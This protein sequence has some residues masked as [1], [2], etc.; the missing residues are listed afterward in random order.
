MLPSIVY[1][2]L[3]VLKVDT[4][5]RL[6]K[7]ISFWV[8]FVVVFFQSFTKVPSVTQFHFHLWIAFH[9][10]PSIH[11]AR[12]LSP[13]SFTVPLYNNLKMQNWAVMVVSRKYSIE[14]TCGYGLRKSAHSSKC[15]FI[16][17]L[18]CTALGQRP[19]WK[20]IYVRAQT[21]LCSAREGL[22]EEEEADR[23]MLNDMIKCI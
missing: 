14:S 5:Y 19:Q 23:E 4:N 1:V 11:L 2:C 9:W 8:S 15:L 22:K 10:F 7:I 3:C 16:L 12:F 18:C 21:C 20:P 17:I 13:F 6:G